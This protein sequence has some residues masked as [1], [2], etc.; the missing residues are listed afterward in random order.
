M[1]TPANWHAREK[2][3]EKKFGTCSG[4]ETAEALVKK[5]KKKGTRES[6]FGAE[7]Q[8]VY[9]LIP[10]KVAPKISYRRKETRGEVDSTG[11]REKDSTIRVQVIPSGGKRTSRKKRVR[12]GKKGGA[13]C[14]PRVIKLKKNA[15]E[16]NTLVSNGGIC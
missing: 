4:G 8:G 3:K 7:P 5:K 13:R 2:G 14:V 6:L 15:R 11:G 10:Q 16:K 1:D 12:N 9:S